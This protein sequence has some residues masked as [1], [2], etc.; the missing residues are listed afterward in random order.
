MLYGLRVVLLPPR[1][2]HHVSAARGCV[3]S[4]DRIPGVYRDG[5]IMFFFY[6]VGGRLF[7][8]FDIA[9]I[10]RRFTEYVSRSFSWRVGGVPHFVQQHDLTCGF[11]RNYISFILYLQV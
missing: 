7:E 8:S 11:I 3:G 1:C 10:L 2:R 5:S 9:E 6:F 4:Y